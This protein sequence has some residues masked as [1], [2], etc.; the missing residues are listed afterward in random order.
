M[1]Y[2]HSEE[3]GRIAVKEQLRRCKMRIRSLTN[4]LSL[5]ALTVSALALVMALNPATH[6]LQPMVLAGDVKPQ[7]VEA[8]PAVAWQVFQDD[9]Y[10]IRFQYPA[11][12]SLQQ[13]NI[14]DVDDKLLIKRVILLGPQGWRGL[15][16]PVSVEIGVGSLKELERVWPGLVAAQDSTT[17]TAAGYR[18]PAWRSSSNEMSYAFEHPAANKLQV[19]FR[20]HTGGTDQEEIVERMLDSF[21]FTL[22]HPLALMPEQ[23]AQ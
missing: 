10:G 1:L 6:A 7:V 20:D 23:L 2:G 19:A 18:V 3:L 5:I 22:I 16:A 14:A 8:K 12:W 17:T 11:D 13:A 4:L 21:E 15:T 9:E